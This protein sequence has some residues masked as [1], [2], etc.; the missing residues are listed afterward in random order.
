MMQEGGPLK[1]LSL[2][3]GSAELPLLRKQTA[4]FAG[5]RA[6]F[7]LPVTYEEISGEN[8]FTHPVR[9]DVAE[10]EDHDADP[11]V[12]PGGPLVVAAKTVATARPRSSTTGPP[13]FPERIRPLS[14]VMRRLTGSS[15]VGILADDGQRR[16]EPARLRP[17][18]AVLGVAEQRDMIAGGRVPRRSMTGARGPATRSMA[19]SLWGSKAIACASGSSRRRASPSCRLDRRPH[20]HW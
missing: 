12:A 5:H 3:V 16:A 8:H 20:G 4:D 7:G 10:G 6:R 18:R 9:D 11:A 14:E 15:P 17:I 2:V 1:P 19:T 13:E